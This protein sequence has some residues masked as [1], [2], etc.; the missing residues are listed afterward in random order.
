MFGIPF[1]S[2]GLVAAMLFVF[3]TL[4]ALGRE[5]DRRSVGFAPIGEDVVVQTRGTSPN[6]GTIYNLGVCCY[7]TVGPGV[8]YCI[9]NNAVCYQ[10]SGTQAQSGY[11]S[12]G[13]DKNITPGG[14]FLC[15]HYALQEGT[16]S[17]GACVATFTGQMC[18]GSW[19][20]YNNQDAN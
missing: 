10:C 18:T 19:V 14:A 3:S 20:A 11:A 13:A 4:A 17:A 5:G 2:V 12:Q 8:C 16:C 6:Y 15:T 1:R 7:N 9:T